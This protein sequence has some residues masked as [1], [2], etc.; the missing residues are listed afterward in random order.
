[1]T[2]NTITPYWHKASYDRFLYKRL[3]QLLADRLPLSGYQAEPTDT[4]T[5]R[6]AVTIEG[7]AGRV[8]V[9]FADLPYPDDD[10]LFNLNGELRT[11]VP[12]AAHSDLDTAEIKCAGELLHDWIDEHMGEAPPDLPWDEALLRAWFP[13]DKWF[14]EFKQTHRHWQLLDATNWLARHSHLRRLL[15]AER[16]ALT[17]PGQFGRVDLFE[18]PE[19]PN[20]GR[21]FSIATGA[22]IRD[23]QLVIDDDS[24][25]GMLGLTSTLIPCLE[26]D[27]PNRLLMGANMMRQWLPYTEPEP[28]LVQTGNEPNAPDFWCGRNLLTAFIPWGEDTFKEGIVLS[29]SGA[30][31]LSNLQHSKIMWH[32]GEPRDLYHKIEPGD[33]LSNRHGIKGVVSRIL[34]DDQ[35][36]K[37]ADGTTVELIFS[38]LKLPGRLNLGQLREALLGRIARHAGTPVLA[39]AFNG[40]DEAAIR[41]RLTAAGLPEDGMEI[42]SSGGTSLDHPS[43]SG[44]LYWGRTDHLAAD[45]LHFS[46]DSSSQGQHMADL[47]VSTLHSLG[48]TEILREHFNTRALAI[49]LDGAEDEP[50]TTRLVAGPIEQATTPTPRFVQLQKRLAAAGIHVELDDDSTLRGTFAQAAPESLALAQ[51]VVHPWLAERTLSAVS[52]FPAVDDRSTGFL[53]LPW[54][55]DTQRDPNDATKPMSEFNDVRQAN[56]KLARLLTS[57]APDSL[58]Q[59]A[60]TQLSTS[61][62]RYLNTLLMPSDLRLDGRASF[63]GRAVLAPGPGLNHDQIGLPEEIA[64]AF[65]GPQVARDLGADAVADRTAHAADLLDEIM[66]ASWIVLNRK[67]T[68]EP[69]AF[70]AFRPIRRPERVV[71]LPSLAC[72][73]LDADFDGDQVAVHLP[74]TAAGQRAADQR[75]SIAAHLKRDP[76]LLARITQQQEAIWGLAYLSLTAEGH[77]GIEKLA[78]VPVNTTDGFVTHTSLIKAMQQVLDE[79]G[80]EPT[81]KVLRLLMQRGFAASTQTGFSMSPFAG[82]SIDKLPVPESGDPDLWQACQEQLAERILATD[83]YGSDLGPYVLGI[84]SGANADSRLRATVY[85]LGVN[86]AVTDVHGQPAI[87]RHG[88]RDGVSP[89]DFIKLVPGAR[90]GMGRIWQQWEEQGATTLNNGA[91]KSFNVLARARRAQHPGVVFARAA[92]T[93]EIDPLVDTDS[94]LFVGLTVY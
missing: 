7:E 34:P 54:Q 66:A 30:R 36:P 94:R 56:E 9:E 11:I 27:D 35:M 71:R 81:L 53:G 69:T 50:L 57:Q 91:V 48:A 32:D 88:F 64:W 21:I 41:Q 77:A 76:S 60:H 17:T 18:V 37:L 12:Q 80:A 70:L 85:M 89:E 46:V 33:K 15:L 78:G 62:G 44:W 38:S 19:G 25:Q 31:H 79:Q 73:L 26:H 82:D 14:D 67:P 63:T 92:A 3:P 75:L 74:I 65:F 84:K 43:L 40:P 4:Y 2:T 83:D 59:Q 42:L 10:G 24:P 1:M 55:P 39:P 90:A 16:T 29:E 22:G 28:A 8:S 72:P 49:T 52:A 5:C 61:V 23:G 93:G 47:E 86:R 6:I 58:V 51:P 87:I 68:M 45:K 20:M 13:L